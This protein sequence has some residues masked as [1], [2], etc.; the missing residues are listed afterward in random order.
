[1]ITMLYYI[2]YIFAIVMLILNMVTDTED[3][4]NDL[5]LYPFVV[6]TIVMIVRQI[7]ISLRHGSTP[8]HIYN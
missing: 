1:M 6:C 8:P 3:Y 2:I 7:I 4:K 5:R